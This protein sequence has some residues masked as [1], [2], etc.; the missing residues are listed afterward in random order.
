MLVG[1]CNHDYSVLGTNSARLFSIHGPVGLLAR[2]M[3]SEAALYRRQ[4]ALDSPPRPDSGPRLRTWSRWFPAPTASHE[5]ISSRI[6]FPASL[7][8]SPHIAC[9]RTD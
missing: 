6:F 5:G 9:P 4:P 8:Y 2:P 1:V 3:R 7:S